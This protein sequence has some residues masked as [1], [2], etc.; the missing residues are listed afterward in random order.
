MKDSYKNYDDGQLIKSLAEDESTQILPQPTYHTSGQYVDSKSKLR[1]FGVSNPS[2]C[3]VYYQS[4][5]ATERHLHEIG[6]NKG[7][8][9]F[10]GLKQQHKS[11]SENK[12]LN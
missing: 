2:G 7:G 8:S 5:K 10:S 6:T 1:L 4:S 3:A 11:D 12:Y 9:I